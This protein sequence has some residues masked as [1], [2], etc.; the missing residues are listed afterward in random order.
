M[1]G[2]EHS[3]PAATPNNKCVGYANLAVIYYISL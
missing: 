2:D 3:K 1:R